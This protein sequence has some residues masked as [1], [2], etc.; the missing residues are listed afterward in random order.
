MTVLPPFDPDV[1]QTI[2]HRPPF[3]FLQHIESLKE[4]ESLLAWMHNDPMASYYQGHYP[5]APLMPG[6]L[7]M[8]ALAQASCY[9]FAKTIRPPKDSRYYLGNVKIRYLNS[10]G[11][12]DRIQL[13]IRNKRIITTGAIFDVCARVENVELATGEMGFICKPGSIE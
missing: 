2:P 5:G 3:L 9:L 12:K 11:P 6:A 4:G 10:A 8:E 7:I 13:D 1:L